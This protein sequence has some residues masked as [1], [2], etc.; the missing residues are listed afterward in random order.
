MNRWAIIVV[1]L[2][3]K[4]Q[5]ASPLNLRSSAELSKPGPWRSLKRESDFDSGWEMGAK[6]GRNSTKWADKVTD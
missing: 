4:H 1:S 3:D 6:I 5:R 2:R